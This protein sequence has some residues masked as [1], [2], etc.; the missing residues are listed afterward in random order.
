MASILANESFQSF[1]ENS[2]NNFQFLTSSSIKLH[3]T[4][5]SKLFIG[6]AAHHSD[7]DETKHESQP[8]RHVWHEE[9][10]KRIP[11]H[12]SAG[13]TSPDYRTCRG[14]AL[15]PE[16]TRVEGKEGYLQHHHGVGDLGDAHGNH[17]HHQPWPEHHDPVADGDDDRQEAL[18]GSELASSAHQIPR[19]ATQ[20]VRTSRH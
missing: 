4:T 10:S 12:R 17:R 8:H 1:L 7:L 11:N 9:R 19:Y 14:E 18:E 16:I 20:N 6:K 3:H 5:L 2:K 13:S 15:R